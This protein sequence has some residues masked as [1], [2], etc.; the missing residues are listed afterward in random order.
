MHGFINGSSVRIHLIIDCYLNDRLNDLIDKAY[1]PDEAKICL[2]QPVSSLHE[3]LLVRAYD[4]HAANYDEFLLELSGDGT[5][6]CS[7]YTTLFFSKIVPIGK[8]LRILDAGVGT[9]MGAVE[10]IN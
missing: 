9:G 7:Y 2:P 5:S 6:G 1:S 8:N 10:L 3:S 4:K